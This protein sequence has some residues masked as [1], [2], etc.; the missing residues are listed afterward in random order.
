MNCVGFFHVQYMSHFDTFKCESTYNSDF[1]RLY[2]STNMFYTYTLGAN[3]SH[4][5]RIALRVLY[6]HKTIN[7]I[8][9]GRHNID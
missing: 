3:G 6:W 1:R 8:G 9:M 2:T 4:S 7:E 5:A